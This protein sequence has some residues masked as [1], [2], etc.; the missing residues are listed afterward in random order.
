MRARVS[1]HVVASLIGLFLIAATHAAPVTERFRTLWRGQWVD[2]VE[3]GDFA[4]TEGD[5]IMGPKAAVREWRIA[6]DAGQRQMLDSR[7]ALTLDSS[8]WL[9]TRSASGMVIVPYTIEA[10]N[11][12]LIANAIAEANRILNG[13]LQWTPRTNEPDYVAFNMNATGGGCYSSIGRVGGRQEIT[14]L[15]NCPTS[16]ILH[17][18]GH[19]MGL[20]HV[21]QFAGAAAFVDTKLGRMGPNDRYNAAPIFGNTRQFDGYDYRSIMHYGAGT[22]AAYLD[23]YVLETKPAGIGIGDA[24]TYSPA[25]VDSLMRLY[26]SAPIRTTISTNPEGRQVI[27]D[28]AMVTTP[29]VFDW[30]IGSVHR[31]WVPAAL[32]TDSS[33]NKFAFGRW[34]HDA[35]TSPSSQL[36]WQVTAGNGLLGNPANS[37]S[38]TVL[39]ANFV[40]LTDVA[41]T[42]TTQIGGT[43]VVTP[44]SAPW[45]GTTSL[46]PQRSVFDITATPNAGFQHYF[47]GGGANFGDT[48]AVAV[49]PNHSV[50]VGAGGGNT[51]GARF[52]GENAIAVDVIGDGVTGSKTKILVYPPSY[53]GSGY[54]ATGPLI[55]FREAGT[56]TLAMRA[57][58]SFS[59]NVRDVLDGFD[60]YDSAERAQVAMPATG[61]RK[62][63]IR[64]HRELSPIVQVIP[65][66]AG[67]VSLSD[68][69]YWLR[70]GSP[71]V[72]TLTSV[73]GAT[74][75]GWSGSVTGMA[76]KLSTT[77]GAV[78]P[79]FVASFNSTATPL[80]VTSVSP[81]ILG[82]ESATTTLTILGT[83]FTPASRVEIAGVFPLVPT[84]VDSNTLRLDVSRNQFSDAGQQRVYVRNALNA[85]CS[86]TSNDA[87]IEILPAG[88][89]VG[90]SLTEYYHSGLDYYFLTGRDADKSALDALAAFARTGREI[91]VFRNANV[92]TLPL[93]RHFFAKVARGGTRGSHF[94]TASPDD[95][96][97]LMTLNPTNA[98]LDAKPYL[99]GVEGYAVPKNATGSCPTNTIPIYRAF[100]G[101]PR[102]VDD[103]NHRFSAS[104]AQHQDMITRLGW[105]DEGVVFCGLQ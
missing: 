23:E 100:K 42:P 48:S 59:S 54:E 87:A 79:E 10:G 72:A 49:N 7:K 57:S 32:Q 68:T 62:V 22:F 70:Y 63:T 76:T 50:N 103:G 96:F 13:V 53:S 40:Q 5:I 43:S 14:G 66:C 51:V 41:F 3:I 71:L 9:W 2:Y 20:L 101:V 67:T 83:G 25:D 1:L 58:S 27:V 74:F 36:T 37:P 44:R 24:F 26:G 6:V 30:P 80:S 102:Y 28:G 55:V 90:I 82:S 93:E 81:K 45:Q 17:E 97:T 85:T 69:N 52:Y 60:G 77:V 56:W 86:V 33:G 47:V 16:T 94:F 73:S 75:A 8:Q 99:E 21:Q 46:Y 29:A 65:T 91:K 12:T 61:T 92:D 104:L 39:T 15:R 89:S 105:T 78:V 64:A 84:Y 35:S 34:S 4:V 38:S 11:S 88:T 98:Q 95:Q 31:L 18:M 19:A